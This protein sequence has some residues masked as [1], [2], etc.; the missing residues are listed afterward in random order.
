[1]QNLAVIQ[2]HARQADGC[3]LSGDVARKG[4]DREDEHGDGLHDREDFLFAEHNFFI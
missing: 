2:A 4:I 1:M 3:G